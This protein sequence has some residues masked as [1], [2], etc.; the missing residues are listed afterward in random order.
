MKTGEIKMNIPQWIEEKQGLFTN[1]SDQ[2]WGF[3]ETGYQ[4]FKS[5]RLLADTLE[6]AGFTVEREIA[7][8]PTAFVASYGSGRP[9][10]AILGE[11]DAL[12]G[13]SQKTA[14]S[15]EPVET[16]GNGHGCGHNL[17]GV[18]SLAAA[19]AV[20]EAIDAGGVEGTIQYYGCP[21]EENGSGKAFMAR[22]GVFDDVD[23]SLTWHPGMFNGSISVNMLSN[24]KVQFKFHGRASHAAADPQNGRSALDAVELMNV[25]VNYLREHIIQEARLHYVIINGGGIAPNVVPPYAESLYLIRAPRPDQLKPI[26]ERVLDVAKGAALMTGTQME[27]AIISGASNLV[28]ND[29][30]VDVLHEKMNEVAPPVFTEEERNFARE[31]APTFP[32]GAGMMDGFANLLGPKAKQLL[33][34]AKENLLLEGVMP[35]FKKDIAMPGSSDVG[36]VS[37]VTPTGQ[38]MTTCYAFGTPGHSW[39]L[40]AQGGM[41]IGH[42]GML[43]AGKVLALTALE[44][45]QSSDLLAKAQDE[46]ATRLKENPPV[47]V[48]PEGVKPPIT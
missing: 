9:I 6:A 10:I 47:P 14:S 27:Y 29:T 36:D 12:P 18:G 25:G 16:G 43:Y 44:F 38:I 48:I 35:A 20:K 5:A 33:A 46:F 22:A 40:V 21:A 4:E 37:W 24:I 1:L 41:S 34:N 19:M 42:K 26:Y 15:Q 2:I 7:E 30:I 28:F 11:F 45:M 23:L 32:Q 39:Q 31:L 17:L 3:A 8:I 13:L